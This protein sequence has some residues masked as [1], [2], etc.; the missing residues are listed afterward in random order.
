MV[1]AIA[2]E[3]SQETY[4]EDF[5]KS[6]KI[7]EKLRKTAYFYISNS[8]RS[9][10]ITL[11]K[12]V[13]ESCELIRTTV[14]LAI[15]LY[16]IYCDY[17]NI[18]NILDLSLIAISCIH[19]ASKVEENDKNIPEISTLLEFANECWNREHIKEMEI[20]ILKFFDW[21][22]L[23]PTAANFID[24]FVN[25]SYDFR[26][27]PIGEFPEDENEIVFDFLDLILEDIR[28]VNISP[29]VMAA[30]CLSATRKQ[31]GYKD[32]WSPLLEELTG[33]K[34]SEIEEY[35]ETLFILK[36]KINKMFKDDDQIKFVDL[37][38][39]SLSKSNVTT[40]V[41][42]TVNII[43]PK[44]SLGNTDWGDNTDEKPHKKMC[45]K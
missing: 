3:I 11:I 32:V 39:S 35:V 17:Y 2:Y 31:I 36:S 16:D 9:E 1:F 18:C 23:V 38:S 8:H 44:R 41:V 40:V 30:A 42:K 6:L 34:Y 21:Y 29:S 25:M 33:Y 4:C 19:I 12:H 43:R 15:Y 13:S 26:D 27:L 5:I 20:Y 10:I 14:H 45:F 22:V 37:A 24:Y 28:L 7:S